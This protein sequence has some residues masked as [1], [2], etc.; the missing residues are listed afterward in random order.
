[1]KKTSI[2]F[3][4]ILFSIFPFL[5]LAADENDEVTSKRELCQVEV[6][7]NTI[8][9]IAGDLD[10]Y[11]GNRPN[12][13]SYPLL[14]MTFFKDQEQLYIDVLAIDNTWHKLFSEDEAILGYFIYQNRLFIVSS[15]GTDVDMN[16][17]FV[18]TDRKRMFSGADA[19]VLPSHKKNP[20]WK[21]RYKG[22]ETVII[23]SANQDS[24]NRSGSSSVK[25]KT[26]SRTS[27][28]KARR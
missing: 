1:M 13:V 24:L 8:E 2:L 20:Y 16:S 14:K 11:V 22:R 27:R 7:D 3:T 4:I 5:K 26:A 21:Y 6:N 25:P 15:K 23:D 12:G 10:R 19:S 9:F 28:A 18:R 17:F